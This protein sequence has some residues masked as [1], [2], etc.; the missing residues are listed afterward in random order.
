M[1]E[2]KIQDPDAGKLGDI[3]TGPGS[4]DE[5]GSPRSQTVE[6]GMGVADVNWAKMSTRM[7]AG[8]GQGRGCQE[9]RSRPAADHREF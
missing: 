5:V 6:P 4:K 9:K 3:G 8:V 2:C 7:A 1:E